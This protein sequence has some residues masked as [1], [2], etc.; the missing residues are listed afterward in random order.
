M[1]AICFIFLFFLN[2]A[3]LGAQTVD[4]L[5]KVEKPAQVDTT[6]KPPTGDTI[7]H[8]EGDV[9][10]QLEVIKEEKVEQHSDSTGAE[11]VRNELVDSTKFSRYG[12]LLNDDTV[13]N[14]RS[15]VWIPAAEVVGIDFLTFAMNR[16]IGQYDY[17]IQVGLSSWKRN[18]LY[19]LEWDVDRFGMNFFLHPYSGSMCFNAGRSNGYNFYQSFAFAIGG[20]VMWEFLGENTKASYNDLINTPVNGAFLGE[21]FYRISS[22][23]LDDR[24]RGT[25]RVL[26]EMGAFVVD[27]VR[28]LNRMIQGKMFSHTNQEVYQKE[29]INITLYAGV[30]K[31]IVKLQDVFQSNQI[32]GIINLQLDYGNP[33]ES[34]VRTKPFDFFKFRL[35]L[36]FGAGRKILDNFSGYGILAGKNFQADSGN[37]SILIGAF[38]HDDYWDN[39]SF[40]LGAIGLG[41]GIITKV[42][43]NKARKSNLYTS[44]HLAVIPFAGNSTRFVP[45]TSIYRDYNFGSGLEGKFESTINIGKYG[46]A[47]L[48]VYYYWIHSYVGLRENNFIGIIKPRVTVTLFKILSVGYEHAFY[49]NDIFSP[50]LPSLHIARTE[51]KIFLMIYLEDKQ[52]RGHYN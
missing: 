17:A 39:N 16:Y 41:G 37:K 2:C 3:W 15:P 25:Q 7:V 4:T 23:I 30:Q 46:S 1:K 47:T 31:Q 5:Q 34:R 43:V 22:N 48:P 11:P 42:P 28:G 9:N 20:S 38:Q 26:R 10:K 51:M 8:T 44:L 36:S 19:G 18:I 40:E 45:D 27:P 6:M 13:Y 52:R 29:P 14:K 35:D 32:N 50:N 49:F 33:F 21:I 24:S 12:N